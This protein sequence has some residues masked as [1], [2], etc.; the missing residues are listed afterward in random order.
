MEREEFFRGL[1]KHFD[2]HKGLLFVDPITWLLR[3]DYT[4]DIIKLDNLLHKRFG[5]YEEEKNMSMSELVEAEYGK[6]ARKWIDN[7]FYPKEV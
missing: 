1:K 3:K 2:I 4:L 7:I 6:E 5:N